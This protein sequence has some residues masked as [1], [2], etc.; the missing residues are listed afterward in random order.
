MVGAY[1]KVLRG[2]CAVLAVVASLSLLTMIVVTCLDVV[3]RRVW[4]RPIT[5][6]YDI[7]E[8]AGAVTLAGAL[9]YTTAV[10]GHIAVEYFFHKFGRRGRIA[11]DTCARLLGFALF[12]CLAWQSVQKGL[13]LRAANRTTATLDIPLYWVPWLIALCSAIVAGVIVYHLLRPGRELIK[14]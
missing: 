8:L 5:G 10:K 13:S 4:G 1:G 3:L 2:L 12:V 11:L 7:V 14:P 9:P 6:A